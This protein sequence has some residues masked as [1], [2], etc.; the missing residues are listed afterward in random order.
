MPAQSVPD[1]AP[2]FLLAEGEMAAR[3]RAHDWSTTTMGS[4]EGWSP[5]LKAMVRMALTTR[6]PIFIFWG[7]EHTCLY[8]DAYSRSLGPEKHPSILGAPGRHA[9]AEIWNIIGPQIEMV[10]RGDGSTWHENQLVPILRHGAIQDVYW[11]YSYGPI[12]DRDAPFGVGGVLVVCTE[13]T[14][15]VLAERRLAG[16]RERFAQLFE[17]AP[18][19]MAL[20]QGPEHRFELVNPA[21]SRLTGHRPVLGRTVA[22]ALPDAVAQGY[23]ARLNQVY[24]SGEAFI[25]WGASY[26]F[27]MSDSDAEVERF[28]DFVYQP[29]KDSAGA[30]TGIFVNGVDMTDRTLASQALGVAQAGLLHSEEQLRLATDSAEVGFWDVDLLTDTLF[31]PARVKAMFGISPDVAVSMA[32]FY[33]GLH[34]DDRDATVAAFAAAMDPLQRSLYDVEFQ[35]IGKEDGVTRWIAA[36]GRALF[37]EDGRCNRVLGTAIDITRRKTTEAS[38]KESDAQLRIAI[39]A[40]K[41]ADRH[42]DVFLATLGHELRNPLATLRNVLKLMESARDNAATTDRALQIMGRQVAQLV[43]LTDDLLDVGRIS[44]GKINLRCEVVAL[45]SVLAQAAESS[46]LSIELAGQHLAMRVPDAPATVYGDPARLV[47][48]FGNLVG[49]ASKFTPAGGHID[50]VVH[51]DG[52]SVVTS[53]KDSGIGMSADKLLCIFEPFRQFE[54]PLARSNTGLGIGLSLAKQ[55]VELHGGDIEARSAGPGHG[56]EFVVRLPLHG[57]I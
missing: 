22:E 54:N 1:P 39:D 40:L 56:S 50:I 53:V 3:M 7:P 21:Y 37:D 30:V 20:L 16:E 34:P 29:L 11:T 31:W 27:R 42:K 49:N 44:H 24:A 15:Q 47:Q 28:V 32:D 18:T 38:L 52:R 13:T 46:T 19:F 43:R 48:L 55:L 26:A 51:L 35:T 57:A 25:A 17:Q 41:D 5:S 8:N 36:K 4:P 14:N 9:W 12:D 33:A 23:L 45:N 10:M 2:S 6:H